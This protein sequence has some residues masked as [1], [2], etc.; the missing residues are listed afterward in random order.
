[1]FRAMTV[2][3]AAVLT[4]APTIGAAGEEAG[5]R[6]PPAEVMEVLH[7]PPLPRVWTSPTGE[8]LLSRAAWRPRAGRDRQGS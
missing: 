5:W 3:I 8:H 6:K 2:L 1:M 7:A 4:L